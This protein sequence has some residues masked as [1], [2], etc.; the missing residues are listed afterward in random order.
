MIKNIKKTLLIL[1]GIFL[2]FSSNA[3]T[4][5][6][7]P[8]SQ[9]GLGNLVGPILPQNRG[10][11]GIAT[12]VRQIGLYSNVNPENPA[13][14]SAIRLTTFEIGMTNSISE[15]SKSNQTESSYTASLGHI[16]FGIPVTKKSAL[17]FGLLPYSNVGYNYRQKATIDT[18]NVDYVYSGDG[19][20]SKAYVGYGFGLGKHISFGFNASYLFGKLSSKRSTE[21]PDDIVTFT[22]S[23]ID[24]SAS[25]S[26]FS[27]DYGA[28]FY[29]KLSKKINLTI[30][31]SGSA[32]SSIDGKYTTLA[33]RYTIN[34]SG[35]ESTAI[36]TSYNQEG[37]KQKIKLPLNNAV[38][39]SISNTNRWLFGA[40]FK[41]GKWSDF[42]VG[43]V[44]Q[45]LNDSYT[46]N[47][48]GQIT[49]DPTAVSNYFNLI[50][51]R[52]GFRYDKSYININNTDITSKAI[53]LGLGLPLPS[54][55]STFYK[56]NIGAELGQRGTLDNGLVRERYANIYIGFT[57]NDQWFIK[58]KFD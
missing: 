32:N 28:Q 12:G 5:T 24:R 6:N 43:N 31:Y 26:G 51:Y 46:V 33:T 34:N 47:V 35:D 19:G 55:R 10:L 17:S 7:S 38:G 9:F 27:F 16:A 3:Q 25:I 11:G 20:L 29:T 2:A 50:D 39:F 13:S 49:P 21:F 40:D 52:L 56:I 42:S 18:N 8:Y 57:L 36:D 41:M 30:G 14:Y 1:G 58:Y 44:N 23:R 37:N 15:L 54:N 48:G 45:G 53:T 22:N 4:T